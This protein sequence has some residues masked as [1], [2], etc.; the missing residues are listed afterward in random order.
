[1]SQ[2]H[3]LTAIIYDKRKRILSIGENSYIKTS[4]IMYKFGRKVGIT[5]RLFLHAEAAAILKL[6]YSER[7]R[8]RSIFV[9]RYSKSDGRP[10]L[11]K[12]CAICQ[13]MIETMLPN[14]KS[15]TWTE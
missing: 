1:M 7:L 10:M 15:I 6:T 11:A 5:N 9:S 13:N 14:I 4:T 2:A 3:Q 12:P 8:A